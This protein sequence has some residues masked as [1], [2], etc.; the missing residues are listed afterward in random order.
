MFL[1]NWIKPIIREVIEELKPII[2]E[3]AKESARQAVKEGMK[4]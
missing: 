2:I 1:L 3:I 4:K